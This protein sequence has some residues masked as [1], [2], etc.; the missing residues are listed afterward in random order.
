MCEFCGQAPTT[1]STKGGRQVPQLDEGAKMLV[2]ALTESAINETREWLR[3]TARSL[4]EYGLTPADIL[5]AWATLTKFLADK[6]V[7][8]LASMVAA[9]VMELAY[10]KGDTAPPEN[11]ERVGQYL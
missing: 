1:P 5:P 10:P 9:A 6:P 8:E 2:R 7:M 3:E 11:A 4:H